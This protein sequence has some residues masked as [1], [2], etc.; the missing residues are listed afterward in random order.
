MWRGREWALPDLCRRVK[1]DPAHVRVVRWRGQ[2]RLL[3]E[4]CQEHGIALRTVVSRLKDQ[5]MP[6]HAALTHPTRRYP[7]GVRRRVRRRRSCS[8][9]AHSAPEP[10]PS[11]VMP[12]P[13]PD[14]ELLDLLLDAFRLLD[15]G[16]PGDTRRADIRARIRERVQ[17]TDWPG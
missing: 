5:Q 7:S 12:A 17:Q 13:K 4:L 3:A 10:A 9:E 8:C 6:L 16:P 14:M 15:G 11:Q 2:N 1:Q